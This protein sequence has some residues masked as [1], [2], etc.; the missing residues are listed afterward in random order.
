MKILPIYAIGHPVLREEN[1]WIKQG[2]KGLNALISAM[3]DTM[4]NAHGVGLAAPQVG[5]NVKIFIADGT[6]MEGMLENDPTPMKGWKKVFINPL[7]VSESGEE[8]DF[9]E[10]CLSVPD[11][12]TDIR[13]KAKI[14][15]RY[16]DENFLEK[17]EEFAG[18]RARII[19]HEH[20]HLEGILFIDHVKGLRKQMLKS[21]L[22]KVS[23]GA[24]ELRYPMEFLK[25]KQPI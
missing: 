9:E 5:Q 2:E 14:V 19:Q 16:F 13:R 18:M 25:K 4:Y 1:R 21:R 3:F 6:P 23:R 11:I 8:W 22:Q 24:I 17:E 10:G 20:D 15:L 7:I 12:K